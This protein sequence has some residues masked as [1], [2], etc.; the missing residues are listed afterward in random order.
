MKA[1]LY[2]C[3]YSVHYHQ[4]AKWL[5]LDNNNNNGKSNNNTFFRIHIM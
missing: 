1:K 4:N 5:S 3:I 2:Y